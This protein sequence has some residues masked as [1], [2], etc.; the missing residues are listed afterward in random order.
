MGESLRPAFLATSSFEDLLRAAQAPLRSYV[1]RLLQ[2][3]E[4]AEEAY[5]I[6]QDVWED[7]WRSAQSGSPPFVSGSD[8]TAIRRWLFH[9]AYCRAVSVLRH[10]RVLKWESLNA[11]PIPLEV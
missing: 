2:P 5:D 1:H 8:E 4:G 10:R 6:V 11:V 7:A 3:G 9:A